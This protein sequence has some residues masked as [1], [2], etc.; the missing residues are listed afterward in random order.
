MTADLMIAAKAVQTADNLDVLLERLRAY[1]RARSDCSDE[2]VRHEAN[3]VAGLHQLPFWGEPYRILVDE[4]P[5]YG[6]DE[7]YSHDYTRV[8]IRSDRQ[9]DDGWRIASRDD[10]IL[11]FGYWRWDS[12]Y[13]AFVAVLPGHHPIHLRVWHNQSW[14]YE[15]IRCDEELGAD[16]GYG[17]AQD[18]A[19]MAAYRV[20]DWMLEL[21]SPKEMLGY[22]DVGGAKEDVRQQELAIILGL[23]KSVISD[24][25]C[26]TGIN[27][28]RAVRT[29]I[30]WMAGI[31]RI[32]GHPSDTKWALFA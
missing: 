11:P 20:V 32:L 22:V 26:E 28:S 19:D 30:M 5:M 27:M 3:D 15:T 12:Q 10:I 8:L 1:E 9:E 6:D 16:Y 24:W 21:A 7:V 13:K 4:Q 31:R 18:A 14:H 17:R 25:M 23:G 29:H 2:F